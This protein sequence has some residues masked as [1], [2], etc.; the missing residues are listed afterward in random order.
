MRRLIGVSVLSLVLAMA[1]SVHADD[2]FR[3]NL[4]SP[5]F[6]AGGGES[7]GPPEG[8]GPPSEGGGVIVG[9]PE[10]IV[11]GGMFR[12]LAPISIPVLV[13]NGSGGYILEDDH[14]DFEVVATGIDGEFTLEGVLM[15]STTVRLTATDILDAASEPVD[16]PISIYDPLVAFGPSSLGTIRVGSPVAFNLSTEGGI[17]DIA[18]EILGISGLS[19]DDDGMATGTP[20]E[21]T[22][23]IRARAMDAFDEASATTEPIQLSVAPNLSVAHGNIST[24]Q[25]QVFSVLPSVSGKIGDLAWSM[26]LD[27]AELP[28]TVSLDPQTGRIH[29]QISTSVPGLRMNVTDSFD[30]QNTST[31]IFSITVVADTT[32]DLFTVTS[33]ANV[34]PRWPATSAAVTVTGFDEPVSITPGAGALVSVDSGPWLSSASISP[35]QSFRLQTT[36]P[37]QGQNLVSN[38][39]IGSL[40]P[41]SWS[42]S[43][44]AETVQMISSSTTAAN[45]Q[46]LFGAAWT[47]SSVR[48]R[49]II[50]SGVTVSSTASTSAAL[51][52]N[53][54]LA[55]SLI[56][57]NNGVIAGAGG[58]GGV[59]GDAAGKAGGT[60]ISLAV[61]GV[62]VINNGIIAG[63]GGGGGLGGRGASGYRVVN[64][65]T[66]ASGESFYFNNTNNPGHN[67]AWYW[68]APADT[69]NPGHSVDWEGSG[70]GNNFTSNANVTSFTSGGCTYYRGSQQMSFYTASKRYAVYRTCESGEAVA[71]GVGGGGGKGA[72]YP[73]AYTAGSSGASSPGNGSGAG[74]KGGN[75]GTYGQ[76]GATG[77]MGNT[78]T[79]GSPSTGVAGGAAGLAISGSP[80]GSSVL[81]TRFGT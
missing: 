44:W 54:A 49:L 64:V 21:G 4:S 53:N 26:A 17:G 72:T 34:E 20:A 37:D 63:G 3:L 43:S 57:E 61:T 8:G 6:F 38:V 76:A 62:K 69:S 15:S 71:G 81:G 33:L 45:P 28:P 25:H 73:G 58:A 32:P 70:K 12:A 19:V 13:D 77:N 35:G 1:A 24:D 39:T 36:A 60:G 50:N 5:I 52:I 30:G 22:Y 29:G 67:T 47:N 55:G 78:G 11:Q 23:S 9:A 42:V 31:G 10:I 46:A 59:S 56:I 27:S 66:P 2:W 41:V 65:R 48:K 7:G 14:P 74:G 51:A 40:A 18:W 75:G 79:N 80:A 16:L 68:L